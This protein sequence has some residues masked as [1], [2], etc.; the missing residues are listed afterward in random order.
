MPGE[1]GWIGR[2]FSTSREF[3]KYAEALGGVARGRE[4]S[5]QDYR[6]HEEYVIATLLWQ[7]SESTRGPN[8]LGQPFVNHFGFID[9]PDPD[10]FVHFI[11]GVHYCG[12]NAGLVS[13]AF[14]LA[15][16]IV[17]IRDLLSDL[18]EGLKQKDPDP[19]DLF[20]D[21]KKLH[22][23]DE[24]AY[25]AWR[26]A[27]SIRITTRDYFAHLMVTFVLFHEFNHA[28]SGHSAFLSNQQNISRLHEYGS[29]SVDGMS[30]QLHRDIEYTADLGA[31]ESIF[32]YI[33]RGTALRRLVK[34]TP[35][36]PKLHRLFLVVLPV[37]CAQWHLMNKKFGDNGLHPEPAA[38]TASSFRLYTLFL[39]ENYPFWRWPLIGRGA[40]KDFGRIARQCED[41]MPLISQL[42]QY[43]QD[44]PFWETREPDQ[45][46]V[47]R[48][49]LKNLY[50][51]YKVRP[52]PYKSK[53]LRATLL[54]GDQPDL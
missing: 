28:I 50:Y 1:E 7:F 32:N 10:A 26:E 48:D 47:R 54:P 16:E 38:R 12:I 44:S 21:A 2:A 20:P 53:V 43:G 45:L 11:D 4:P 17:L 8:A 25:A 49:E 39:V 19:L 14:Y 9:C 52:K 18:G 22:A 35:K 33:H 15:N 51:P 34:D 29:L 5:N 42:S 6:Q 41:L 36:V 3:D 13:M 40:V 31:I 27:S 30:S 46:L 24:L 37:L 23:S